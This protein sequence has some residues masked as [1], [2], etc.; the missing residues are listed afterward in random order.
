MRP[1]SMHYFP[2]AWPFIAVLFVLF[3]SMVALIELQILKYAYQRLGIQPRYVFA[4]LL[5]SLFGS[6]INIPI[7]ELPPETMVTNRLVV[8]YGVQYVV[9]VVQEWPRTIIALNVGGA[10]IPILLS[11][12]LVIKTDL[13]VRGIL[14]TAGVAVVVHLLAYPIQG[15]GIAVPIFIPPVAAAVFAMTLA[16][17]N[18]AQLAYIAGSMGT[19]IGADL[20]NLHRIHGLGAPVASIGGAGTFDGVFLTGILAVLLS[21]ISDDP[22]RPA[23]HHS[24]AL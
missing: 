17:K 6:A 20:L 16:R 5:A 11:V 15:V 23:H 1:S 9:P 21:P 3:V 22:L 7:A 12:Y 2:L 24:V 4:I 13:Y 10:I 14:A 19:L 8:F 18:A